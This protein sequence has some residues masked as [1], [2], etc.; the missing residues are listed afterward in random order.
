MA[1]LFAL[2]VLLAS[3]MAFWVLL[4]ILNHAG[5]THKSLRERLVSRMT[6]I[7]F[8]LGKTRMA[9]MAKTIE[10][11]FE[12]GSACAR[13]C[14]QRGLEMTPQAGC[15][16]IL[17]LAGASMVVCTIIAQSWLGLVVGCIGSCVAIVTLGSSLKHARRRAIEREMPRVFRS[18]AASLA[19]GRTLPQ[20]L[21]CLGK[22]RELS[23][24]AYSRAALTMA[25]GYSATD[26]LAQLAQELDTPGGELLVN[27]LLVSHRTGSPL[28]GL[29]QRAAL[30]VEREGDFERLLRVKTAQV[31]LSVRVVCLL[32]AVMVG[33]LVLI[34]PDFRA[35]LATSAGRASLALAVMLDLLAIAII[36]RLLAS[37]IR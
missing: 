22:N 20:A 2:T 3:F 5:H 27:A 25:C 24:Q 18:L 31:K 12:T 4:G 30:I 6:A 29:F 19:A 14:G 1:I 13:F 35:G 15:V 26:A 28:M 8:R 33:L 10:P 37:V 9:R 7:M 11:L 17:L 16:M 23:S 21:A 36:R 34:S 32:P